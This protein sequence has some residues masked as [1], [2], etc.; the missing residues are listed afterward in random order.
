MKSETI[1]FYSEGQ[2]IYGNLHLPYKGS[3]CIITLHGLESSKDSIKWLMIASKLYEEGYA[4]LRFNFRGCGEGEEKSEGMFEDVTL[5]ARIN[6]YRSAL[7]FL[8]S[9]G[10][11][12]MNRLGVIGSSFGGMVAIAGKDPRVKAIVTLGTPYKIPRFDRPMIPR[13]EGEYYI[14]P[15]GRRF[16][17]TFYE[18]LKKYDLLRDIKDA[19]PILIIHGSSDTIVPLEHAK[20]LYEAA[21]SPKRF[22]II[23]G[24]D[25][26]FSN[27]DHLKR[28]IDL[29]LE[30]F[31]RY[32]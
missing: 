15:S 14:L 28:V 6:D 30:W 8:Q 4:C 25:H 31:K 5:S 22:E 23:D 13:E 10:K 1:T 9:T 27:N 7:Q 32:L 11:V 17:R 3:P 19:P 18:D 12:D 16:K 29:S 24:A 2:K 21:S 20:R 26:V